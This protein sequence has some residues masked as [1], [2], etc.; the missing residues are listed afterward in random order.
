[1]SQPYLETL[2]AVLSSFIS[3]FFIHCAPFLGSASSA[4]AAEVSQE[5]LLWVAKKCVRLGL[6][7]STT[8]GQ[9]FLSTLV[10]LYNSVPFRTNS[11]SAWFK[12][13][14]D[15]NFR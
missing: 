5:H 2:L 14:V 9:F 3:V 8:V 10:P 7:H 1:M 6:P 15:D 11:A 4:A 12:A 13:S